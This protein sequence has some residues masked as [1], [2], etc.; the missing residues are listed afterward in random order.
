MTGVSRRFGA[1]LFLCACVLAVH[2]MV[3]AGAA[4]SKRGERQREGGS[5]PAGADEAWMAQV[6]RS[7]EEERYH[8][9]RES[10]G[11]EGWRADNPAQGFRGRFDGKGLTITR[12]TDADTGSAAWEWSLALRGWGRPG[13]LETMAAGSLAAEGSRVELLREARLTE[14]FDNRQEG[15][16]H[17]FTIAEPPG[18]QSGGNRGDRVVFDLELSGGLRPVFSEDGQAIDFY[19]DGGMSV[20][21]Y[22]T[23]VVTDATGKRLAAWMEPIASGLRIVVDDTD[24]AYPVTVDP[25][26]TIP[27]WTGSGD[28]DGAFF[29]YSVA[30]AGD[31]NGDGYADVI[32]GAY[33][34]DAGAACIAC[35][36]AYVYLGSAS[37]LATG[38]IWTGTGDEELAR[39]GN[40]VA[41]AGDVNGDGYADVIVGAY[42]H[43]AGGGL[44][45]DR[46]R[47]YV[48]LGSASGLSAA[49]SWVGSGDENGAY[50]GVSVATAGD[51]NGDG[52]ADVIVGAWLHDAG[53]GPGANRGRA[54]VYLGSASGLSAIPA[55]TG[56]GDENG[57]FF[58]KAVSTA[59][60]VNGDGY[61]DVIV[62]ANG[63]DA[64]AG[65]GANRGRAYV[66]LG[67]TSGLSLAP[68]WTGSG[69]E[70]GASFGWSV[71]TAGDVNGDGYAEV[72]V[73]A[74]SHDAGGGLNVLRG[75]AYVYLGTASGPAASASW[76]GSGDE[77]GAV[78]GFAVATA[79]DVNGDGYADVVVGAYWHDA[80]AGAGADRGRAYV[81]LGSSSGLV[82]SPAWTGSGDE[83]AAD[84]GC[85]VAT[86]GDVNGDGYSDLIVGA[87]KHDANAGA[88]A[89]RGR[90]YA[91]HGSASGP[92]AGATWTGSGDE[93]GA[94]FGLSVATAGD[95][96]GDGYSDV[97]VGA[98]A[99]DAG[100]GAGADRGRAY[101]YLGSA[102][103]LAAIPAWIGSG[104]EN[105]ASFGYSVGTAG[106]VNGDGYADLIVG[107][108]AHD[109][110]AGA[111]ANRGR[112]Y[113]YLGSPSG[114]V[115]TPAWTGDGDE[116]S[117]FFG[118]AVATAGDVNGDSYADVVVGAYAH[119]A[120]AGPGADRGRAYVYL[121]S[122]SGLAVTPA[123]SAE[124]DE[125]GAV[126]GRAVAGAGDVNG[127]GYSDVL[128]G[129]HQ[130][131]A[132]AGLNA[133]RGRAYLYLGSASG[134]AVS[135]AWIASGDENGASFG[136]ALA[137]AGDVNGDGY[138]DV[139]VGAYAHDGGGGINANRGRAYLYLG[140]ASGL[141]TSP[142]SALSGDENAA[143]F[144][145]SVGTAGDVN[146]DGYSDVV[147]GAYQHDAGAGGGADRGRAYVY[148]GSALGLVT[149][150]AWVGSG[151]ENP[152]YF[153]YAVATAGD[154]NGDGYADVVVGAF[155]HD[156]G[157]GGGADR[158]RAYVHRGGGGGG[159]AFLPRQWRADG[160]TPI[161]PGGLAHGQEFRV[162]LRLQPPPMGV[163]TARRL[164]WQVRPWGGRFGPP[165]APIES[166]VFW[167]DMPEEVDSLLTLGLNNRRYIWR[168]RVQYHPAQSPFV[169]WSRWLT[170]GGNGLYEADVYST[171]QPVP[172]PCIAPDEETYI[173][174]VT[175]DINGKPVLH[176]LDANQ[177][178]DVTG[179][180]IYRASSPVGPWTMIGSNVVD[181]DEGTPNNQYV[182]QTGDVGGPWYYKIAPFN[183]ACGAE[184]PW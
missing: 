42:Y 104:D 7:I 139:I 129:A 131:D 86:A 118:I 55:W 16:E 181:M 105:A 84:F 88:N 168:A 161:S 102:A 149:G 133:N 121:G 31:V 62:G 12:G 113:L 5:P 111:G 9:V 107:A 128:V 54:H 100:A 27:S 26:A 17:G 79:G 148:V 95:V 117:A 74:Y 8:A 40:S 175:L 72:I 25:L 14:W 21:R 58:G 48:F 176:Y 18:G 75:R 127:D 101:V 132:G 141:A 137:T 98:P 177:P 36:R 82:A 89:D 23:L 163:S 126:F 178:S 146:G 135:P 13:A 6:K 145:I 70:D 49:P 39:F 56:D 152:C 50:F 3:E 60:D 90:A 116:N 158:G 94:Q 112:A 154:V 46:G 138:S 68:F 106:D 170:I 169:G 119:D 63:D 51:V 19:A 33:E 81:Y 80:G 103:G 2:P 167:Y 53:G 160:S 155:L 87:F 35:G 142:V 41:T 115:T 140:S 73:G 67:S 43:D 24:A 130:H 10:G 30:T 78:F 15:L 159:V 99:H 59:G 1:F 171:S 4:T 110:G 136:R 92:A 69:D 157:A 32:V 93:N 182:D 65:T 122:A 108:Y 20:L 34:H 71:A 96:N 172:P 66:S 61:S 166:D 109:A 162:G 151:D 173:E 165:V 57:A 184:G 164:Q 91:Y 147:V 64:G 45:A 97:V 52:Y 22:A 124:G 77:D 123:W 174:N 179:F 143:Y 37:G 153:G 183:G 134:L 29:G 180:N 28:E 11:G 38:P 120:G 47:A 83:N 114:L 150:S 85:S 156:A 144:G 76:T 125:N 44:G